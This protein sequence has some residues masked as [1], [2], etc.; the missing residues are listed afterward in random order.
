MNLFN[1]SIDNYFIF[2][3]SIIPITILIGP[4]I[5]LINILAIVVSFIIFYLRRNLSFLLKKKVFLFLCFLYVYLIL[6][7]FLSIDFEIS[8]NRNFGFI[9]YIILFITINFFCL[10]FYNFK[11]ILKFWTIIFSLVLF[12][13]IFELY[14]GHNILGYVSENKKRVVSFFKDEAVVGAFLN[15]FIFII[16]GFLFTDFEKKKFLYKTL[17]FLF[18][19]ISLICLIYSGE[20][21]NT[22][23]LIIGLSIFFYF[24]N[25]I[26]LKYKI[27]LTVTLLF[28]FLISIMNSPYVKHR[29]VNDLV[30]KIID[31]K[32]RQNYI[33]FKLYNSGFEVFKNYPFFGVGNKNY[34]VDTFKSL[35]DKND[36]YICNTHPHQIYFEFLSEHGIFGSLVLLIILFYL[37]FRNIKIMLIKN[38]LIQIGC[39]S[40]LIINFIPV[41]PGGSFFADFNANFFWIN[42]SLFYA[43]NSDTNIFKQKINN[44]S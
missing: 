21:S 26:N 43:L 22:I 19:L 18:I 7:S 44:E 31:K 41:L 14:N 12:D 33:Y 11:K 15:G 5:S 42:F 35:H 37:I 40:Y 28:L 24:N 39:F 2:L 36:E 9:R 32:S 13:V 23:K 1:K 10:K 3:F 25:K 17:I 20:R 4:A 8:M 27:V 30:E 38:N 34:I 29:Y 16:L 6:N